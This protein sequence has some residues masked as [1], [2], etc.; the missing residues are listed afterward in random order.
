VTHTII[1]QG[2]LKPSAIVRTRPRYP[3]LLWRIKAADN[4]LQGFVQHILPRLHAQITAG[5][6]AYL[7]GHV[8]VCLPN[9]PAR[10]LRLWWSAALYCR[11]RFLTATL[12]LTR[13]RQQ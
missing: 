3:S 10:H 8:S 7:V 13:H 2:V 1:L 4:S 6:A 12:S 9:T 5:A 11:P